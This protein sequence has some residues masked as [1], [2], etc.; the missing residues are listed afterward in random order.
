DIS[1]LRLGSM[2]GARAQ[3]ILCSGLDDKVDALSINHFRV[4][5]QIL[6]SVKIRVPITI[7]WAC[8][9]P[10]EKRDSTILEDIPWIAYLQYLEDL[11][12]MHGD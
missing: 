7:E 5:F 4:Q 3:A 10:S 11:D 8:S 9:T 6:N 1:S 2:S 12:G